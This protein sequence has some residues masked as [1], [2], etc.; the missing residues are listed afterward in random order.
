MATHLRL[1][2]PLIF[3]I[4]L[5]VTFSTPFIARAA[6]LTSHDLKAPRETQRQTCLDRANSPLSRLFGNPGLFF[7]PEAYYESC[8]KEIKDAELARQP[9]PAETPFT[10]DYALSRVALPTPVSAQEDEPRLVKAAPPKKPLGVADETKSATQGAQITPTPVIPTPAKTALTAEEQD[11]LER[12]CA[13]TPGISGV[14]ERVDNCVIEGGGVLRNVDMSAWAPDSAGAA[15]IAQEAQRDEGVTRQ[16]TDTPQRTVS[17][18]RLQPVKIPEESSGNPIGNF[19]R[20]VDNSIS[21]FAGWKRRADRKDESDYRLD[22]TTPAPAIP[23]SPA[24]RP[25]RGTMS[26]G[27]DFQEGAGDT[28]FY[29]LTNDDWFGRRSNG[30]GGGFMNASLNFPAQGRTDFI[31]AA[32]DRC[33][34]DPN[35]NC[36]SNLINDPRA[37]QFLWT[38]GLPSAQT[39]GGFTGFSPQQP[40]PASVE[41]ETPATEEAPRTGA[42]STDWFRA[43]P[44]PNF[45]ETIVPVD[46]GD[47]GYIDQSIDDTQASN[48]PTR[49]FST[50]VPF[51]GVLFNQSLAASAFGA[52]LT[53]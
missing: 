29:T 18:N 8:L 45:K 21:D 38:G 3:T 27:Y 22:K 10:P 15:V 46:Y 33:A 53:R 7:N 23:S 25:A 48:K 4:S 16:E 9:A 32:A 26:V 5:I 41:T 12:K 1:A 40:A 34:N 35:P 49:E 6:I 28:G 42:E 39:F 19:F 37:S 11:R 20:W 30:Y 52:F 47:G 43:N 51:S 2:L 14:P 36:F 24:E 44:V 31:S 50:A 17:L 13:L